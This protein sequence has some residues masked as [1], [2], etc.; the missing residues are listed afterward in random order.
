[1]ER[2][3]IYRTSSL[4]PFSVNETLFHLPGEFFLSLFGQWS[5]LSFTGPAL[6]F[7]FRSMERSFIYRT[8]SLFPFS[9]NGTL[10]HLPDQLSFS[11]FGQ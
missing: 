10:F 6:F 4:F 7:P 1:M 8:S 5:A 3:F 2:S 9:V 11:L